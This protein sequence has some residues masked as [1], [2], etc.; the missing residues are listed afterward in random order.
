MPSGTPLWGIR[1]HRETGMEKAV[2][3]KAVMEKAVMEKAIVKKTG[4]ETDAERSRTMHK[5]EH[6]YD[7]H[8][9]D[10]MIHMPHP[11]SVNHPPMGIQERAAQFAPFA[12]LAGHGEAVRET[13]RCTQQRRELDED[14]AAVLDSRLQLLRRHILKQPEVSVEY[15]EPDEGKDGGTYVTVTGKAAG[16]DVSRQCVVMADGREIPVEEIVE[17]IFVSKSDI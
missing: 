7:E 17:M 1:G 9:Y 16:M 10:D 12:A 8:R 11:V 4:I 6:R 3:K 2:M 15:F 5:D 14:Y 13:E